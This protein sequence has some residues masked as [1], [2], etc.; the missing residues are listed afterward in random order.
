VRVNGANPANAGER[1]RRPSTVVGVPSKTSGLQRILFT[2]SYVTGIGHVPAC[3]SLLRDIQ[4]AIRA[5][6]ANAWERERQTLIERRMRGTCRC[7]STY[8]LF[9]TLDQRLRS[10]RVMMTV[11]A[12]HVRMRMSVMVMN[13][14]GMRMIAMRMFMI[15]MT[16]H[17]HGR[18][19]RMFFNLPLPGR[20]SSRAT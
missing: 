8:E 13:I 16:L 2:F 10:K 14:P 6:Q 19:R 11:G 17:D 20:R 18:R 1:D 4:L 5:N 3:P 12:G 7:G 15:G 9:S